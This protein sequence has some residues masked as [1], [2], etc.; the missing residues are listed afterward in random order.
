MK[1]LFAVLGIM[2][3]LGSALAAKPLEESAQLFETF[4]KSGTYIKYAAEVSEFY[5]LKNSITEI[6]YNSDTFSVIAD[7]KYVI[8]NFRWADKN[9]VLE[10]GNII[11]TN[12]N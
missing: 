1:K 6:K 9:V 5:I 4:L 3:F 2:L 8:E 12:K 10:N 11:I 7:G